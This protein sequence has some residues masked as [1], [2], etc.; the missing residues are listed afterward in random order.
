MFKVVF[1]ELRPVLQQFLCQPHSTG[2]RHSL[3]PNPDP[4]HRT[5]TPKYSLSIHPDSGSSSDPDATNIAAIPPATCSTATKVFPGPSQRAAV[6]G[7][8]LTRS[9]SSHLA[10]IWRRNR[11]VSISSCLHAK[12]RP[13]LTAHSPGLSPHSARNR[14]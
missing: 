13:V 3:S 10:Q 9:R 2:P 1:C 8:S 4:L 14:P 6:H 7:H 12:T 5:V 11:L